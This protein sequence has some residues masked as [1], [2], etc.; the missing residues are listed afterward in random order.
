MYRGEYKST[1]SNGLNEEYQVNDVVL[2]EGSLYKALKTTKQ[3]PFQNQEAWKFIKIGNIF[4]SN[5]PPIN[6]VEGQQW[7]RNGII[8]TYYFNEENYSW[9]EF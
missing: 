2:F 8:Y 9:V 7:Q 6:P 3:S 1:N 4:V 5:T